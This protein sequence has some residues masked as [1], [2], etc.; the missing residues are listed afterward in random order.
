MD[1]LVRRTE[2]GRHGVRSSR[3]R[4]EG[5]QPATNQQQA[6]EIK[7][8]FQLQQVS[9]CLRQVMRTAGSSKQTQWQLPEL[10]PSRARR[11]IPGSAKSTSEEIIKG[12]RRGVSSTRLQRNP[13]RA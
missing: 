5:R 12:E 1:R 10:P 3:Q 2:E 11:H 7:G 6:R 9:R 4:Q 8:D 13:R